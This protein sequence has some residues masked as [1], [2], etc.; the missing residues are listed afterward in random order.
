MYPSEWY[1]WKTFADEGGKLIDSET[2]YFN[3]DDAVGDASEALKLQGKIAYIELVFDYGEDVDH[4]LTLT[5]NADGEVVV[6]S[7]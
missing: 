5:K 2:G 1:R 3:K 6:L 4:V 7:D